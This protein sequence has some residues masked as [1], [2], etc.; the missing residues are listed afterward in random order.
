MPVQQVKRP[1]DPAW[2]RQPYR[3]QFGREFLDH[4][5]QRIAVDEPHPGDF[6]GQAGLHVLW[7]IRQRDGP[8]L[9][10]QQPHDDRRLLSSAQRYGAAMRRGW[11]CTKPA[12]R[13]Q[14]GQ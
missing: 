9:R 13:G 6:L 8:T 3:L 1:F 14:C 11:N 7:Q 4:R 12:K 2:K 10:Q 5:L